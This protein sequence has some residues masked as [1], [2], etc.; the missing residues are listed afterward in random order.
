[1][2]LAAEWVRCRAWLLPALERGRLFFSEADVIDRLVTGEYCLCG[3]E[4]SAIVYTVTDYPAAR[5]LVFLLAGGVLTEIAEMEQ[6]L[7]EKAK[8]LNCDR[9]EYCGRRGW[10]RAL[11]YDEVFSVGIKDI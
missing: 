4:Q 6:A 11:G 10:T 3:G 9:V 7:I 5:A 8:I 1:M 2:D